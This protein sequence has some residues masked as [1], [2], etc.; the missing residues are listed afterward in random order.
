[1]ALRDEIK[2]KA[3]VCIDEVCATSEAANAYFFPV[4]NML[5]EAAGWVI[6]AVPLRALG[7]GKDI[8]TAGLETRAD[9][10]GMLPLPEDFV[11][12]LSFRMEGWHR[13]VV[14]PI[15]N[16]DGAYVQQFNPVLRGGDSKPV[17]ALCEEERRLEYF[18]SSRG[19]DAEIA[20]ARYF[21]FTALGD[22]YPRRLADITAWKTAELVLAV[23]NDTAAM[24]I[25]AGKVNEILQLL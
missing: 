23:L 11:R 24:Q 17:V 18:S 15:R 20:E 9:G 6:R 22:D 7:S 21:G 2:D 1:M 3:L 4:D 8:P 19:R 16:T 5:D 13:P 14:V 25:C 12:L 10:T